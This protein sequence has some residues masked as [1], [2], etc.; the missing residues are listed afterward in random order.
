MSNQ[1]LAK[2]RTMLQVTGADY[3]LLSAGDNV[4]Y[5]SHFEVPVEFGALATLS[6][7]SPLALIGVRD[8]AA[9]LLTPAFYEAAA[10]QAAAGFES[11]SYEPVNWF[12]PVDGRQNFLN[13][14][15]DSLKQAGLG[16]GSPTLT[17][18]EKTLPAAAL[19]LIMREF[20]NVSIQTTAGDALSAA[21]LIKTD[22]ELQKLR[23][24]AEVNKAG[25]TELLR[26]TREAGKNE[27]AMWSAV[28]QAM[29]RTAGHPLMVFG[30]LV[31]GTRCKMVNYPGGP[32]DVLTRPGDL[33][34]MD[35]SPRVDGYWS[36]TTNTM[37]IGGVEPT[38]KQKRYGVAAR[39]A[40]HAAADS[41]R[42]GRLAKEAYFAAESTFEKH[43]LRI[44][45]YAGHQIGASVN[46]APR[47][48]PYDETPIQAGMV[49]SIEPGAYEGPDGEVGA[50]MEKSVIVHESGPEI[51]CD[52][53]WGF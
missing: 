2:A 1:E 9:V 26:Q 16:Q 12:T 39:E 13:L 31:T 36:D 6:F 11:L 45:H 34:L 53:E 43:G 49:F 3:A 40:F 8:S 20:P 28:T 21:R 17:I 29:E 33:A 41:L 51:I 19:L 37:V 47:L 18:E 44:G 38:A 50:R 22:R 27:F 52:F 10:Q 24:A 46:E 32:K 15:R 42:P 30:E 5:V 14:L 48:V 25:H 4:T 23:F 7:I 35:M